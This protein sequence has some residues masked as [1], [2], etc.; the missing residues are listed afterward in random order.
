MSDVFCTMQSF[1]KNTLILY[2]RFLLRYHRFSVT[3]LD[4]VLDDGAKLIAGYHG[5]GL[6]MDLAMV[7]YEIYRRKGYFPHAVMHRR[8]WQIP[9]VRDVVDG[10]GAVPSEVPKLAEAIARGESFLVAPGGTREAFRRFDVR[11]QVNFG[12][13]RGYL[14]MALQHGLP[15]VPVA[16]WGVDDRYLG[17]VDGHALADRLGM[18][19]DSLIWL[20]I[21]LG[22]VF[23]LALP[24]P[25]RI[26]TVIGAPIDVHSASNKTPGSPEHLDELNDLVT[27]RIQDLLEEARV[28]HKN[29]SHRGVLS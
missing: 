25:V 22:G 13:R 24:F 26:H 2:T 5:R 16:S 19:S 14:R 7:G 12:R 8:L 29:R 17:L 21:G 18:P 28:G 15:I 1:W 11:Y 6:P 10:W 4:H 23:P 20:G 27:G 9:V 3:G